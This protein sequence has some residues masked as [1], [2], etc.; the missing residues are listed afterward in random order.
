M[1][2]TIKLSCSIARRSLRLQKKRLASSESELHTGNWKHVMLD[3]KNDLQNPIGFFGYLPLNIIFI[4]FRKM[5]GW[6]Y[7]FFACRPKV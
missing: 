6:L 5:S 3:G 4:V 1:S 7:I 2:S